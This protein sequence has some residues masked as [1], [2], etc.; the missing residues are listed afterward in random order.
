MILMFTDEASNIVISLN[1]QVEVNL[2]ILAA[3]YYYFFATFE[4]FS[5]KLYIDA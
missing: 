3:V 4:Q 5:R 1:K 2:V